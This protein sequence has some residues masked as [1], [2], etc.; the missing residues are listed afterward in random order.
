[1][2]AAGSSSTMRSGQRSM[3]RASSRRC[4]SPPERVC[5]GVSSRWAMLSR[6]SHG[7]FAACGMS[8][9][10]RR[11]VIGRSAGGWNFCGTKLVFSPLMRLIVPREGRLW[12]RMSESSVL[13]P[14]PF[15]PTMVRIWSRLML[16]LMSCR[17]SRPLALKA[18]SLRVMRA[19][20]G[21]RI[22]MKLY[23]I[24]FRRQNQC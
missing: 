14:A 13:L 18:M 22:K 9:R 17:M 11:A 24:G 15:G 1:M 7:L 21:V 2:P 3:A 5:S 6:V 10:K 19:L 23:V 4:V 20:M 8:R 12:P 16:K